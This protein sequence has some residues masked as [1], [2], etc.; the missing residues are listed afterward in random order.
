MI[1]RVSRCRLCFRQAT[2]VVKLPRS[3]RKRRG[4]NG[5][6]DLSTVDDLIVNPALVQTVEIV[7]ARLLLPRSCRSTTLP[8]LMS[9]PMNPA[10]FGNPANRTILW[11]S[12]KLVRG[13]KIRIIGH[14]ILEFPILPAV[15]NLTSDYEPT[16]LSRSKPCQVSYEN[17]RPRSRLYY[18]AF[19]FQGVI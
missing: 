8:H 3:N 10:E 19:S 4:I 13:R 14:L 11:K 16:F 15:M 6:D 2:I 17:N 12:R 7:T 5:A 9:L 18:Q 1:H